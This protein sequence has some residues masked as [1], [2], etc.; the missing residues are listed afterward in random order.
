MGDI[1][2]LVYG[3]ARNGPAGAQ[4]LGSAFA[5]ASDRVATAFH[6]IG[7]DD[8]DLVLI[9]PRLQ[10]LGDYQD[11]EDS[12]IR[13]VPLTVSSVD[14]IRDLCVLGLPPD[15]SIDHGLAL[16]STDIVPPGANVATY[17][18]PHANHGRL[19]LT[20]HR[21]HVGARILV[22]NASVK[23]KHIVLNTQ[24]REGQSGG[25]VLAES[26][27]N[28]VAMVLGSYAPGGG[29]GISLGGIDPATLHQTTHAVSAEYIA[30]MLS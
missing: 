29:G 11:P 30:E 14:P 2:Q 13:S 4:L 23:S 7:A 16:T 6:V 25:P 28:V 27:G 19:V 26:T 15:V 17:G 18:F 22:A 10:E 9:L 3:V 8:R 1:S 5:V 12:Q 20:Q 21:T 24:A